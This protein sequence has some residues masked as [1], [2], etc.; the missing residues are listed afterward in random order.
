VLQANLADISSNGL[1][2]HC[3]QD[4]RLGERLALKLRFANAPGRLI[5]CR[6]RHCRQAAPQLFHVGLE[7]IE[8]LTLPTGD[9]PIPERWIPT[10]RTSDR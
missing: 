8:M 1:G 7:F 9:C 10:P 2:F 5:L 3:R 4:F 6:I